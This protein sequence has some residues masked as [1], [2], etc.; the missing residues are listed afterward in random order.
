[1]DELLL[2]GVASADYFLG[3]WYGNSGDLGIGDM[4]A[5]A[6]APLE[7]VRWHAAVARMGVPVIF[8]DHPIALQ[9]LA[10]D[11]CG[12]LPFWVENQNGYFWAF[13]PDDSEHL[14]LFR[15]SGSNTWE[16]AGET[17]ERFLLHCTVRE[18]V[19]GTERKFTVFV[20]ESQL[21]ESLE[22]FS[23]LS[24]PA[25]AS[26]EPVTRMWSSDDALIR[27]TVPPVGYERPGEQLWM[28][29]FA[30]PYD[31]S[32]EKYASR[33]GLNV[34]GKIS[35]RDIGTSNETPPF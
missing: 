25:L 26:E 15:M 21:A 4:T 13:N 3:R 35:S 32:I 16:Q 12:M 10:R 22:S 20:P 24:F 29:T 8:Q 2:G 9:D 34:P 5:H 1:M 7:L 27:A 6:L 11:S 18:A 33:Y 23:Q 30:V 14:V 17:L 28:L 19:I 31:G